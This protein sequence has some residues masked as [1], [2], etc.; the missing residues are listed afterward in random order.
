MLN[1][2]GQVLAIFEIFGDNGKYYLILDNIWHF[3]ITAVS[4]FQYLDFSNKC[5]SSNKSNIF[6]EQ[7]FI[8]GLQHVKVKKSKWKSLE[9]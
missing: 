6:N 5:L 4:I 9:I 8:L 1:K 3:S 2:T 7:K